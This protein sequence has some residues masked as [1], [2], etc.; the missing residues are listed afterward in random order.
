MAKDISE[1][2]FSS[3]VS[4]NMITNIVRVVV[5]ALVGL[6]M[7][8][9]YIDQFGMATYALLPLVTSLT[10]YIQ[11]ASDSLGE[12]FARY[13]T[14]DIHNGDREHTNITYSSS[15]IGMFRIMLLILPA[16]VL[17]SLISP[18]IFSTGSAQ[19]YEVQ[20]MFFLVLLSSLLMSFIT[21]LNSVYMAY[22]YLYWLYIIRVG[23][24]LLQ[25]GL[26]LMF[27]FV[28]GPSLILLGVSYIVATVLM[29][30]FLFYG[31]KKIDPELKI[32][33]SNYD[34]KH[35]REMSKLGGWSM[36]AKLGDLMFIQA[37][38]IVVNIMLGSQSQGEF[39]I[40]TNV[41][42]IVF[43]VCASI[44]AVGVPLTYKYYAEKDN[45]KMT[46]T[47]G[48]F[49]KFAGLIML[50]PL[51]YI[52][53]F[54]PQILSAWLSA[55]YP[56]VVNMIRI[57]IPLCL[58][59][60]VINILEYIPILYAKVKTMS[61][62]VCAIGALNVI[63]AIILVVCT[64]LDTYG[65]CI[66]WC[67]SMFVLNIVFFPLYTSMITGIRKWTFYKPI[68]F[69]YVIFGVI[70]GLGLIL[71]SVFTL[72]SKWIAIILS[73]LVS[74]VVYLL[75]AIRFG[76]SSKEKHTMSGY[77]PERMRNIMNKIMGVRRTA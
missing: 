32:S 37:S 34:K 49:T 31:V 21:C 39:S 6:L 17:I 12:S 29:V 59:K 13:L 38:M 43:T 73:A 10:T 1:E 58:S 69:N 40:A 48:I 2:K 54:A 74:Y 9:Y 63:M 60:C 36:V 24:T 66:A 45:E 55:D 3:K 44:A 51:A 35:I 71:C 62:A 11:I 68:I 19:N 16:I 26:I 8:P 7:V 65:V 30:I 4:L 14:I 27:F 15:V 42:S 41:V 20:L 46:I 77:F 47:L 67:I 75:V 56:N 72:P 76:L 28:Q 52:C 61:I 5:M 70:M 64:D 23:H 22:N 50:F 57:M 53:L 18:F 33:K 25:V